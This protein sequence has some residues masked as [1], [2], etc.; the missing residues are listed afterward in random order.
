MN[1]WNHSTNTYR[2]PYISLFLTGAKVTF[3]NH[4]CDGDSSYMR[5][6]N[7]Y[8]IYLQV[9]VHTMGALYEY[10]NNTGN[11]DF[12]SGETLNIGNFFNL[13]IRWLDNLMILLPNCSYRR[14]PSSCYI[15]WRGPY[16]WWASWIIHIK[17]I[18]WQLGISGKA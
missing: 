9:N 3:G 1:S 14:L 13:M 12:L 10:N 4:F 7:G 18:S 6:Q 5:I 17:R 11:F 2:K 8:P 16:N 15:S